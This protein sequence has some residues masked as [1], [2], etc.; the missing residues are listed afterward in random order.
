MPSYRVLAAIAFVVTCTAC[1]NQTFVTEQ[2]HKSSALDCNDVGVSMRKGRRG[3]VSG[4]VSGMP[5]ISV[6]CMT[7]R[8]QHDLQPHDPCLVRDPPA[9]VHSFR[10]W[11]IAWCARQTFRRWG[12]PH[13]GDYADDAVPASSAC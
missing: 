11:K 6:C 4:T 8:T 10:R 12:T 13:A 2:L 1:A 9:C 7:R 3:R 5:A